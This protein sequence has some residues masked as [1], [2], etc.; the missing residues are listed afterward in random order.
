MLIGM[1]RK[2]G[3]LMM[4]NREGKTARI[5]VLTY[6]RTVGSGK[7]VEARALDRNKVNS[8]IVTGVQMKNTHPEVSN[9]AARGL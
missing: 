3:K 5:I 9:W 4:H 7:E 1:I 8:S 2:R 6:V